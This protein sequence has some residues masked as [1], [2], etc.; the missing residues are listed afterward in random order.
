MWKT[1]RFVNDTIAQTMMSAFGAWAMTTSPF[2]SLK[3]FFS[4]IVVLAFQ[5]LH[6]DLFF[7]RN[8]FF[9][10]HILDCFEYITYT[11][12]SFIYFENTRIDI[13][14]ASDGRRVT[15]LLCDALHA[16]RHSFF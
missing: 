13:R 16:F 7:A 5:E 3:N 15:Q 2:L 9:R 1:N 11:V 4:V 8:V 12:R 6:Y 10:S 14:T